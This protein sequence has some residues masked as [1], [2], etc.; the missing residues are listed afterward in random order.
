M[1]HYPNATLRRHGDTKARTM[2][3]FGKHLY[4]WA[5]TCGRAT[6]IASGANHSH[7]AR[8]LRTGAMSA[9]LSALRRSGRVVMSHVPVDAHKL[10]VRRADR[11]SGGRA[12]L[13]LGPWRRTA[14]VD[15][16]VR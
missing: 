9:T 12:L 14:G 7:R 11:V 15:E 5:Q 4:E 1:T 6:M 16:K 8:P 13:F 10:L 3:R 2:T